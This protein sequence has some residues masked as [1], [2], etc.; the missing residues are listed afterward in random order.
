[1]NGIICDKYGSKYT[2]Y[3]NPHCNG[4]AI[5]GNV[6]LSC[7]EAFPTC[8]GGRVGVSK[9]SPTEI[10]TGPCLAVPTACTAVGDFPTIDAMGKTGIVCIKSLKYVWHQNI[11]L[12]VRA[13]NL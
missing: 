13:Q 9:G 6:A 5:G 1:V 8:F 11:V 2:V 12:L 3:D 10:G 4:D 7:P